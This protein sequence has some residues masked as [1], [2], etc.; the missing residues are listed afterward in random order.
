VTRYL[1]VA[2]GTRGDVDPFVALGGILAG[3]GHDVTVHTHAGYEAAARHRGAR[4]VAVDSV[5]A[6]QRH[7]RRTRDL[8]RKPESGGIGAYYRD[9]E[10]FLDRVS[11][12][13]G[14]DQLRGEID[15]LLAAGTGTVLVGRLHSALSVLIAA[16]L[17]GAP[18]CQISLTPFQQL[19]APVTALHLA[20]SAGGRLNA[21]RAE[22][23]LP[24]VRAWVPWLTRAD[25]RVGLWPRWFDEAGTRSPDGVL[26]TGFPL[27]DQRPGAPTVTRPDRGAAVLITG[28]TGRM[29]HDAFY[30]A[31]LAG[32]AAAG[33][34]GIVVTPHR[35]LLPRRL[36]RGVEHRPAL[37]FAEAMPTVAA[38][39]HHGGIG[40]VAR[41]LA[42]GTPQLLLADGGDRPDNARRLERLG[43]ARWL[44]PQRWDAATVGAQLAELGTEPATVPAGMSE[45][46][47]ALEAV[48]DGLASMVHSW[49]SGAPASRS[50]SR[51]VEA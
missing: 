42:A 30:P 10:L 3:R 8:I 31:A 17:T 35:D 50:R 47:A 12:A 6:Y 15:G 29:L 46:S 22:Y 13:G 33:R 36:P 44:A 11:I 49:S 21:L 18:V 24:P 34:P 9:P 48:A 51:R 28:G 5:A 37:P 2:H 43:L 25:L 19:T 38:V 26:L 39:V 32:L 14:F 4:F 20:R 41:A 23:G 16:E 40:T 45:P 7:L 1:I 27:A